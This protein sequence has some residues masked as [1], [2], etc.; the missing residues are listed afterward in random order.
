VLRRA[1]HQAEEP[2]GPPRV[3]VVNDD[4]DA[5]ELLCRILARAGY[6]VDRAVDHMDAIA[7]ASEE[8]TDCFL[9]DL[10]TGG[11]GNNLKLLDSIRSHPDP[12]VSQARVVLVAKQT[13]NRMF[14]WQ[15]GVDAFLLRP[16]HED[17]LLREVS[18][19]LQRPED[20]R[21]RHRRRQLNEAKGEGR[22]VEARPWDTQR[23]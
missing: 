3:L 17:D 6:A 22:V 10:A 1:K 5:C 9:L 2:A 18:E 11:I 15:A 23:F 13:N 14:S 4:Q 16:F 21:V 20:D 7:A 12:T 19:S 8:R